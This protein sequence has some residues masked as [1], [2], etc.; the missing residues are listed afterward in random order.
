MNGFVGSTNKLDGQIVEAGAEGALFGCSAARF[1]A[2]RGR[3]SAAEGAPVVL[4]ARPEHMA[5]STTKSP[6]SLSGA[7]DAVLPSGR[8]SSTR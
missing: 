8:H 3:T 5:V 2:V 1:L 7:V 6:G 4:T